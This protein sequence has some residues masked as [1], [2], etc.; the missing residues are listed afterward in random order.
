M[1]RYEVGVV[2]VWG[3]LATILVA[4][5]CWDS[6][7]VAAAYG[8]TTFSRVSIIVDIYWLMAAKLN[9]AFLKSVSFSALFAV[10]TGLYYSYIFLLTRII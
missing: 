8:K 10:R 1:S 4:L 6:N 2:R 5:C 7:L 3:S 9:V